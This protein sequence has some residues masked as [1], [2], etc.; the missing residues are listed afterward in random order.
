MNI[1]LKIDDTDWQ[2]FF[3]RLYTVVKSPDTL[4]K[5]AFLMIWPQEAASHFD[6]EQG[7]NGPWAPWKGSTRNS[8][9]IHEIRSAIGKQHKK[10]S[11]ED[12]RL[13]RLTMKQKAAGQRKVSEKQGQLYSQG[14][15]S[16]LGGK[17]LQVSGRLRT[18]TVHE[19]ILTQTW[20]GLKVESPTPY[21]GWLDEG[22][23]Y[24]DARPFMW[25]GDSAQENLS[26]VFAELIGDAA[27]GMD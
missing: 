11:E 26:Q 21:S 3:E 17:L 27:G 7:F 19:P 25:L 13:P 15:L 10:P 9:I 16:R 18:E 8:R 22:T 12:M 14:K 20:A 2:N 4:L 6:Q 5:R 23:K 24:M 1:Q